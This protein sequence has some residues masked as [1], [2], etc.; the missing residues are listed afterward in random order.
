MFIY[1]DTTV[2]GSQEDLLLWSLLNLLMLLRRD[3]TW[4]VRCFLDVRSVLLLLQTHGKDLKKCVDELEPYVIPHR[5]RKSTEQNH[6]DSLNDMMR[7]PDPILLTIMIGGM[8]A[9]VVMRHH[10]LLMVSDPGLL[11]GHLGHPL[12]GGLVVIHTHVPALLASISM[13]DHGSPAPVRRAHHSTSPQRKDEHQ[14]K[15]PGQAK[16]HDEKCRSDTP[17]Y[18]DCL[19]AD[20]GH[21]VTPPAPDSERCWALGRSPRPSPPGDG[22]VVIRTHVPALLNSVTMLDHGHALLPKEGNITGL[23]PQ[24]ERRSTKQNHQ[25]KLKNMIR[26][27][28][29]ILPNT[30]IAGMLTLVMM[31]HRRHLIVSDA[32]RWIGHPGHPLQDD[33]IAIHTRAPALLN[34]VA[35]HDV[36]HNEH[37]SLMTLYS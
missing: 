16:E 17:D 5:E 19:A 34:S 8:L 29:P 2:V 6:Q 24:R 3:I 4:T 11:V 15:S 32:G 36:P 31:K 27:A 14:T 18:N 9:L 13:L 23:L 26:T 33:L 37:F 20:N 30:M 21:D 10:R 22:L 28:D 35:V 1:Q 7:S 12:Q 25:D